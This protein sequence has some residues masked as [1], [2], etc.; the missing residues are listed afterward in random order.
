MRPPGRPGAML[1][2]PGVEPAYPVTS[3]RLRDGER[4]VEVSGSAGFVRQI[5]E[6][7]PALIAR[8][9]GEP[10]PTPSSIRMPPPPTLTAPAAPEGSPPA[11]DPL[12]SGDAPREPEDGTDPLESRVLAAL[13]AASHPLAVAAIRGRLGDEVTGQ[14]VRRILERAGRRVIATGDRPI[15]YRLR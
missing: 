5:L 1:G 8:L 12:P 14:Q 9:R 2:R 10:A 11:A 3:F 7:L 15:R 4:E 6:D 13:G